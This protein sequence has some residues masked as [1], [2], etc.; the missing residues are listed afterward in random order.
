MEKNFSFKAYYKDGTNKI[1]GGKANIPE[2]LKYDFDGLLSWEEYNKICSNQ[3]SAKEVVDLAKKLYNVKCDN[4]I[5]NMEIIN[6]STGEV[7]VSS[8]N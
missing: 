8:I 7:V 6:I 5:V 3:L 1:L 4:S 2:N